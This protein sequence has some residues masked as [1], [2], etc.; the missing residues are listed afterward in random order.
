MADSFN[1]SPDEGDGFTYEHTDDRGELWLDFIADTGDGGNSTYTVASALA[2]PMLSVRLPPPGSMNHGMGSSAAASL[3][4][5]V[6]HLPL[7]A[8]KGQDAVSVNGSDVTD[9]R[10][11]GA[12]R[13]SAG[14]GADAAVLPSADVRQSG[15]EASLGCDSSWQ[16]ALLPEPGKS[17]TAVDVLPAAGRLLLPRGDML[18]VGGDLAYPNPSK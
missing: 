8:C 3:L 2:A 13:V 1:D 5:Q 4:S 14:G 11:V 16:Q 12:C 18:L 7:A 6:T 10:G 15:S 17:V 9:A